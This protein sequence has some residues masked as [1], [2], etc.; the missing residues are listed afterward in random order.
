MTYIQIIEFI[1]MVLSMAGSW[2]AIGTDHKKNKNA[3]GIGFA[4][5]SLS[6]FAMMFFAFYAELYALLVQMFIFNVS[7]LFGVYRFTKKEIS[8]PI[9]AFGLLVWIFLSYSLFN[10]ESIP[11]EEIS[12]LELI[13]AVIAVIGVYS[14]LSKEKKLI[15]LAFICYFVADILYV[16]VAYKSGHLFFGILSAFYIFS[17]MKGFF[18]FN[19]IK[20]KLGL[21]NTSV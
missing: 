2:Y 20:I 17:S 21:I 14:Y 19:N 13:A 11:F 3:K 10:M 15:N 18:A 6:N 4:L 16:F 12:T 7:S 9:I 1:A 8:Y 5:F